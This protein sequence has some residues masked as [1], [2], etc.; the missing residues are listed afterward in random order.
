MPK[1]S[2][3]TL[4]RELKALTVT[5]EQLLSF[6]VLLDAFLQDVERNRTEEEQKNFL[7]RFLE[8]AFYAGC[9]LPGVNAY[10]LVLYST[11]K[12]TDIEVLM[13]VKST[14]N[15]TEM[16]TP[17]ELNKKALQQLVV[18]YL[19]ER[20]TNKNKSLRHLV[21]TN[22]YTFF[23][24]DATVFYEE[25]YK[26]HAKTFCEI[27]TGQHEIAKSADM[28][29]AFAYNAIEAVK[30]AL[31]FDYV[32]LREYRDAIQEVLDGKENK[33]LTELYKFFSPSH[34]L[35]RPLHR[36]PNQLDRHFYNELLYL[37]GLEEQ[38]GMG[39]K[40]VIARARKP[41]YASLIEQTYVKVELAFDSFLQREQYGA[42]SAEQKFNIALELVI[43]WLNR[44]LF[45][46]LLETQL[47]N[48]NAANS[49]L[50]FLNKAKIRDFTALNNLFFAV[51]AIPIEQRSGAFKE[52]FCHVPYLNSSLFEE[53]ALEHEV[54]ISGLESQE[55]LPLYA[56][57]ILKKERVDLPEAL[58]IFDYLFA[59][60][61]AYD[62]GSWQEDETMQRKTLINASVLGLIFEKING[63]KDGAVFTPSYITA[64]ICRETIERA[65]IDKFNTHY[66]WQCKNI[67]ELYNH[68]D[69]VRR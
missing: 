47:L 48:Y 17:H 46:K 11:E 27:E 29:K 30:S 61:E 69:S 40:I 56:Q 5:K 14:S 66:D 43:T 28:Y 63:H 9:T 52:R 8:T 3:F 44:I 2:H 12:K 55:C 67:T 4:R 31:P 18:Y 19:R 60:L 16:P 68:L 54:K 39:S 6:A 7:Q 10:D 26:K 15:T 64:Y 65:I 58:P 42:T 1:Q 32:D 50:Q 22:L 53:T 38:K 25:F 33:E 36:E 34:L 59:F 57:S 37:L 20:V 24:F 41:N 21:V 13:E 51:L 23:C 35:K 62:F 45:L 49:A